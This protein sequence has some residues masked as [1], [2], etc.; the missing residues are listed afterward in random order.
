MHMHIDLMTKVI[1][2]SEK[3]YWAL[4]QLKRGKESFSDVVLRMTRD[5]EPSSLIDFAG[6]WEGDDADEVLSGVM[7]E[8]ESTATREH[9]I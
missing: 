7:R 9:V 1:S 8:R 5:A 3:A 2:L 6:R 4:R